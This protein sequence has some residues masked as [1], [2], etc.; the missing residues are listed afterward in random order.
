MT[1]AD[2][3]R[4]FLINLFMLLGFVALSSMARRPREKPSSPLPAWAEGFLFG[5]MAVLA[6]AVPTIT[7]PGV[8]FDCRSGVI[9]AG[10]LLGGP[11]CALTSVILP[12]LYRL[13]IGGAGL[14]PGLMEIM[15]PA[16]LGSLCYRRRLNRHQP[17]TVSYAVLFSLIIGIISN[18]F[19]VIFLMLFMPH[20]ELLLDTGSMMLI[21]LDGPL[22]MALF[23]S[24][25]VLERQ[26]AKSME[27]HASIL[28]TSME[29]FW[30]VDSQGHLLEV[31]EAYCRMSGYSEAELLTKNIVDLEAV[32][33]S[34]EIGQRIKKIADKGWDRF[35]S[36]HR[37]KDGSCFSVGVS[38]Q[39]LPDNSGRSVA[40]QR[41]ITDRKSAEAA[42]RES[43]KKYKQLIETTDTG[44]VILDEKGKVLDANREYVRMTGHDSLSDI[45]GRPVT[46]WTAP[47]DRQRNADEVQK[48]LETGSVRNLEIK[49]IGAGGKIVPVEI[50]AN[51][52]PGEASPRIMSVCR[53][54][55]ERQLA[56]E[57]KQSLQG[58]LFRAQKIESIG[59]LASG[60]A[61]DFNNILSPIMG[62]CD[63]LMNDLSGDPRLQ[64]KI[65][66]IQESAKNASDLVNQMLALGRPSGS[67]KKPVRVQEIVEDV[68]SL[69]EHSL[70]EGIDIDLKIDESCSTILADA[71]QLH[72]VLMNLITNANHAM[73]D[74]GGELEIGLR[75]IQIDSDNLREPT[76]KPGRHLDLYVSDTGAGMDEYIIEKIFDPFFT[77]KKFG[78]GTGL[79]LSVSY[80]IIQAHGGA[81]VVTSAPGRGSIFHVYLPY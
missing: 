42:L 79:G 13:S 80:G 25:L 56:L 41:D 36:V 62:I 37:R 29:G 65:R 71:S 45:L 10:A 40:F 7:S 1:F 27:L 17:L 9:G 22:S 15:L 70:P 61:H 58:Q 31:N 24:L 67:G 30:L 38:I 43:E 73:E 68:L 47:E 53:D 76:L 52:L 34:R 59:T 5:F 48:C 60:L 26:H 74:T 57:E 63:I 78:K 28:L 4:G 81:I 16:F 33:D 39:Y 46:E 14:I 19:I 35:E 21:I 54:I 20:P 69:I 11:V 64:D 72:Q 66:I 12:G 3:A 23:S 75:E 55:T 50:Q 8:F 77:T 6:M 49:Y 51:M 44:F 18:G 32:M 2:L